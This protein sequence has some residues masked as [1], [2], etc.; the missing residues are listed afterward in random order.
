MTYRELLI[1]LE[2]MSN[3]QLNCDVTVY[4]NEIDE[5]MPLS[6]NPWCFG[7]QQIAFAQAH[8]HDV[9]DPDHPFLVV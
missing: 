5:F 3:E 1:E 7:G 6:S 9:I 2:N 8:L 4:V